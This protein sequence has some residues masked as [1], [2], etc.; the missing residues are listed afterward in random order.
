MQDKIDFSD[1]SHAT[2]TDDEWFTDGQYHYNYSGQRGLWKG[3][4]NHEGKWI[5]ASK[6]NPNTEKKEVSLLVHQGRLF[7]RHADWPDMPF[8]EYDPE[9]LEPLADQ[10]VF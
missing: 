5:G 8:Q 3:A 9:I 6:V 2:N 10:P 7:V 4:R 1:F